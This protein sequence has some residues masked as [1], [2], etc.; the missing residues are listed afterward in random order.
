MNLPNKLT[1]SRIILTFVFMFFLFSSWWPGKYLALLIFIIACLTDY[2]DGYIAKQKNM[3]TNFGRLAD[4]IADKI[5]VLAAFLAFVE[6]KILPAWM[7]VLIILRELIITGVRLLAFSRGKVLPAKKEGKHKTVSQ[8]LAIFSILV[9]L[10]FRETLSRFFGLWNI[11]FEIMFRRTVF[12]LMLVTVA[13]TLSS[14]LL[15]LWRNKGILSAN[16]D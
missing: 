6:L 16:F 11:S 15:Y 1:I 14:G 8:M 13:L 12:I 3:I 10:A 2:Y 9:F 4:P 5:L 7:V